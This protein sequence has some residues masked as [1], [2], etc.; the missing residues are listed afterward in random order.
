MDDIQQKIDDYLGEYRTQF[1][2]RIFPKLHILEDHIA[3]WISFTGFGMVLMGAQGGESAYRMFNGLKRWTNPVKR[4]QS[5]M[6]C[7]LLA[8]NPKVTNNVINP[9]EKRRNHKG[10][11]KRD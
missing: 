11:V 8:T 1:P 7:H 5:M 3:L 2:L 4:L 9:K 10:G 6:K